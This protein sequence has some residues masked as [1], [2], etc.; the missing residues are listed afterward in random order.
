MTHPDPIRGALNP[1]VGGTLLLWSLALAGDAAERA[2]R[3]D[4][5][6]PRVVFYRAIEG[7]AACVYA[8]PAQRAAVAGILPVGAEPSTWVCVQQVAG[9]SAGSDA[10]WHYVVETDVLPAHEADFN[11]W[12]EQE[13]LPGLAAVPGTVGASRFV[14]EGPG[15]PRYRACYDLASIETFGSVPWLAV[16]DSAWSSR[17]R[18]A[19]RATRRIMF[20]RV[21]PGAAKTPA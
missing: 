11:A 6:T 1:G 13:H 21:G 7:D 8:G 15:G 4:A 17:V 18:P 3:L 12:Y 2:G 10:P 5:L 14:R 20:E 19:F 9:A 16:R